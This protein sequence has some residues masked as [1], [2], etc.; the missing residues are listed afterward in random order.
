MKKI[1]F[2]FCVIVWG[3]QLK[4]QVVAGYHDCKMHYVLLNPPAN[5]LCSYGCYSE[6]LIDLDGDLQNDFS[7]A[8]YNSGGL[9]GNA[10]GSDLRPLGSGQIANGWTDSSF[11]AGCNPQWSYYDRADTLKFNDSINN[12]LNW[13]NSRQIFRASGYLMGGNPPCNY[14]SPNDPSYGGKYI[15][16]RIFKNSDTLYGWIKFGSGGLVEIGCEVK[17]YAPLINTPLTDV[18]LNCGDSYSHALNVIASTEVYYQWAKNGVDMP[19][20]TT[21]LLSINSVS[22][23]DSGI[24]S[25]MVWNC[26]DT[27]YTSAIISVNIPP[28]LQID[29]PRID[30]ESIIRCSGIG[31]F[32]YL[33]VNNLQSNV[34]SYQWLKNDV[35]LI[36][37]TN[38]TLL[39]YATSTQVTGSYSCRVTVLINDYCADTS[40]TQI[41]T[42]NA[43]KYDVYD[44]PF[45]IITQIGNR[46]I[47]NYDEGN[48]WNFQSEFSCCEFLGTDKEII[49]KEDGLYSLDVNIVG[50][51]A[52]T[53]F[54][55]YFVQFTV[56]PNPFENEITV[57]LD[58][59]NRD[60]SWELVNDLGITVLKGKMYSAQN[61]INTTTIAKGHYYLK[62][63][64]QVMKMIKQ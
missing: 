11:S 30:R 45:P 61:S 22:P 8:V 50:C 48:S 6:Y 26:F 23:S 24:Y 36:G 4:A 29:T 53:G 43:I 51:S 2:I 15:G 21:G 34:Q 25:C 49:I 39:I 17:P 62:I 55:R 32:D 37:E 33:V 9:G 12:N 38:D 14:S 18:T 20:A 54:I 46:L 40:Y 63:N 41:F 19:G 35:P 58:S 42:T 57:S 28:I 1:L 16:L 47:S 64:G 52:G 31:H 7:Y 10:G 5:P 27:V 44:F 56:N 13:R 59:K 3:P 60:V